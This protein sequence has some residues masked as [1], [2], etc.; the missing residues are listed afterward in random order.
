MGCCGFYA[1]SFDFSLRMV[2]ILF[3][4]ILFLRE[5]LNA[6]L[7][8]AQS[9]NQ[10]ASYS[11]RSNNATHPGPISEGHPSW[12]STYPMDIQ[13]GQAQLLKHNQ[14]FY[15][16]P[17]TDAWAR[18]RPL[19]TYLSNTSESRLHS[20]NSYTNHNQLYP[21]PRSLTATALPYIPDE[22]RTSYTTNALMRTSFSDLKARGSHD[23]RQHT[24]VDY[25]LSR[26]PRFS[27]SIEESTVTYHDTYMHFDDEQRGYNRYSMSHLPQGSI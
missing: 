7:L 25:P 10:S 17:G 20:F 11:P 23:D 27:F 2:G 1:V 15:S 22:H 13:S 24:S 19:T 5:Q 14:H 6:S 16:H 8:G 12:L 4:W 21:V 9:Q 26:P 3:G 18:L